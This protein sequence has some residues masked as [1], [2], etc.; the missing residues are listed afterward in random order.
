M[1]IVAGHVPTSMSDSDT[2]I[3]EDQPIFLE[4]PAQKHYGHRY[5]EHGHD[6]KHGT[7]W[8]DV[9]DGGRDVTH[10]AILSLCLNMVVVLLKCAAGSTLHSLSLMAE[11]S[12][13]VSDSLSDMLTLACMYKARKKPSEKFPLGYAKLEPLGSCLSSLMLLLTSVGIGIQALFQVVEIVLP[14]YQGWVRYFLSWIPV[15]HDH[16]HHHSHGI[17]QEHGTSLHGLALVAFSMLAKEAMYHMMRKTARVAQSSV[18]EV[19]AFHQR[20]ESLGSAMSLVTIMF[21]SYGYGWLDSFFGIF[22]AVYNGREAWHLTLSS[23]E[24]LCDCSASPETVREVQEQMERAVIRAQQLPELPTFTWNNLIV[25]L[26]GSGLCMYVTLSLS[27]RTTLKRALAAEAWVQEYF[28]THYTKVRTI[29]GHKRPWL[30][31]RLC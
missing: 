23:L 31:E 19:S 11:A 8:S 18:L 13:A 6:H 21:S 12:H 4:K 2:T 25:V 3:H 26:H 20:M 10:V 28:H 1:A 15:L 24:Q 17:E 27:P 9:F 16:N 22:R 5:D 29:N 30:M 14:S 7:D